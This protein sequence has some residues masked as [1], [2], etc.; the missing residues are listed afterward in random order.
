MPGPGTAHVLEGLTAATASWFANPRGVRFHPCGTP[1]LAFLAG[2]RCEL[3]RGEGRRARERK[4]LGRSSVT[5]TCPN[6]TASP[7]ARR[8]VG[9]RPTLF[10]F[11][12]PGRASF[13]LTSPKASDSPRLVV[14]QIARTTARG[15]GYRTER[16]AGAATVRTVD[17][18]V[19]H[20]TVQVDS[21]EGRQRSAIPRCRR[22]R[23]TC[24]RS[25]MNTVPTYTQILVIEGTARAKTRFFARLNKA[26]V[27]DKVEFGLMTALVYA[28]SHKIQVG[29]RY[30]P[31]WY[32]DQFRTIRR[33]VRF[34]DPVI[35][36]EPAP[37]VIGKRQVE[38]MVVSAVWPITHEQLVFLSEV[39]PG[40]TLSRGHL[41]L[42]VRTC[43]RRYTAREQ[44]VDQ[45][46]AGLR[47]RRDLRPCR[48]P[49]GTMQRRA[50]AEMPR[51][52]Q[53]GGPR[54]RPQSSYLL[55]PATCGTR[56]VFAPTSR[57]L[58]GLVPAGDRHRSDSADQTRCKTGGSGYWLSGGPSGPAEW[59]W[60]SRG[61]PGGSCRV[62]GG[63]GHA[64]W[65]PT[66]SR[67]SLRPHRS[68]W[69]SRAALGLGERVGVELRRDEMLRPTRASSRCAR[70][71]RGQRLADLTAPLWQTA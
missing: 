58:P 4:R 37:A 29:S 54:S 1:A 18:P 70:R 42:L 46:P 11:L 16:T 69:S 62:G 3:P 55:A 22:L 27:G 65:R 31:G 30:V 6:N 53:V 23:Q 21:Q 41:R 71:C 51:D 59:V 60:T 10:E 45:R 48:L 26:R 34:S 19:L 68:G 36:A 47:G 24:R 38:V 15:N 52:S 7:Q 33:Q 32:T 61:K 17:V 56:V 12:P 49:I 50:C 39:S 5:T 20:R 8:P 66:R 28:R 9:A 40:L 67:R 13:L 43:R 14:P 63:A 57:H 2:C 64:R 35:I 25:P 44:N